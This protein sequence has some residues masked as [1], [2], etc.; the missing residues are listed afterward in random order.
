M[1]KTFADIVARTE[2]LNVGGVSVTITEPSLK[3]I[4]AVESRVGQILGEDG[5][6]PA[7]KWAKEGE[8]ISREI[9]AVVIETCMRPDHPDVE[10]AELLG[11]PIS[12]FNQ[13]TNRCVPF[14]SGDLRMPPSGSTEDSEQ[15]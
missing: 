14:F 2:T 1:S 9:L 13:L 5:P 15:G 3:G 11:L 4:S 7:D 10:C 12:A 6:V 8:G